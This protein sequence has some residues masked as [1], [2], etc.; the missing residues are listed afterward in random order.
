[1]NVIKSQVQVEESIF[2]SNIQ[3]CYD[4]FYVPA[5]SL[6]TLIDERILYRAYLIISIGLKLLKNRIAFWM[7]SFCLQASPTA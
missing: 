7:G 5:F 1:M 6:D 3:Y 2:P 4:S